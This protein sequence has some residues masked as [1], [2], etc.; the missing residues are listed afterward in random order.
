MWRLDHRLVEQTHAVAAVHAAALM[1]S[2]LKKRR[3]KMKKHKHRKWL[4]KMK[5]VWAGLKK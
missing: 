1:S 5:S 4:K 3:R 2:T